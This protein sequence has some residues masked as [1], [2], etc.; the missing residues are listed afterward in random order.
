MSIVTK[1]GDSGSTFLCRGK[2]ISKDHLRVETNGTLDE[3]CSFLG[4]A[5][6]LAEDGKIRKIIATVQ[7]ELFLIGPEVATGKRF[8]KQLKTR[9]NKN[10]VAGL[11]EII[12]QL[13]SRQDTVEGY[14]YLPG[15]SFFSGVL[16]VNRTVARRLERRLVT[17]KRKKMLFN[18]QIIV[19]VNRLSDMLF[20]LARRQEKKH[21]RITIS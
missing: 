11:E 1:K 18:R 14:F 2:K 8:L 13:E 21:H 17:L 15:G 3:L 7:K 16:D 12:K 9:I 10:H 6:S 5:R 20:L 4:M 19:Y